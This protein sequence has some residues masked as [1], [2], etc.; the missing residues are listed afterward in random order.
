MLI[1]LKPGR[2]RSQQNAQNV[3]RSCWGLQDKESNVEVCH[4][5]THYWTVTQSSIACGRKCHKR[6]AT[7][8]NADCPMGGNNKL[9]KALC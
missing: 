3:V 8:V 2:P 9:N 7:L 4:R 6:C 5:L 1:S